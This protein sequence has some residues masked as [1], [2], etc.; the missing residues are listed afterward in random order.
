MKEQDKAM[1]RD[2]S[3]RGI[4]NM[5]DRKFKVM[6]IRI[7][8]RFEK[9]VEVMNETL[10]TEIRNNIIEIKGSINKMRN[11]FDGMDNRQKEAEKRINDTEDRVMETDQAK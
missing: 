10:D 9:R 7:L 1:A 8:T 3:K 11:T 5:C 6:I 4:N 2:L